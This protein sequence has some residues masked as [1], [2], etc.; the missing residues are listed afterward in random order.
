[1]ENECE[2]LV[3]VR[4]RG[5]KTAGAI[6]LAIGIAFL[7]IGIIFSVGALSSGGGEL[8]RAFGMASGFV[9]FSAFVLSCLFMLIGLIL[10]FVGRSQSKR[11][12]NQNI[13][14]A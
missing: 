14:H 10:Y 7:V 4:G 9:A 6:L 8:D 5:K 1:M 2:K 3:D 11:Q 12:K 13:P